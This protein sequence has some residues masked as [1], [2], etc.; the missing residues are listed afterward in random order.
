[1]GES[2][3]G[4]SVGVQLLAYN[5]RDDKLFAGAIS[6]SGNPATVA[7]YGTFTSWA[8]IV[9]N[10]AA[11]VGCQNSTQLL[12]CLRAVPVERLNAVINSTATAGATYSAVIDGDL[13]AKAAS[14][15]LQGG[16]FVRVPF[17]L[18]TNTDEGECDRGLQMS[19]EKRHQHLM[20][21]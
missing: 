7:P 13:V 15:Q 1:M 5:G 21:I 20:H 19:L 16:N 2:A 10:I 17:L 3:G 14:V 11:G 6:E 8:P 4:I 18:G 12:D 9:A